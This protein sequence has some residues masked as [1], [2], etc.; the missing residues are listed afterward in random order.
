MCSSDLKKLYQTVLIELKHIFTVETK[1]F[2]VEFLSFVCKRTGYTLE[3]FQKEVQKNIFQFP[4][5]YITHA[6]L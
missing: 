6:K 1:T 4:F 2:D 5:S 3:N